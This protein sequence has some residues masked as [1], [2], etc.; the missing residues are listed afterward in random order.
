[1]TG[2]MATFAACALRSCNDAGALLMSKTFFVTLASEAGASPVSDGRFRICEN[3]AEEAAAN[4]FRSLTVDD[5]RLTRTR[6]LMTLSPDFMPA[7]NSASSPDWSCAGVPFAVVGLT[8]SETGTETVRVLV[9]PS[10]EGFAA[11]PAEFRK[12]SDRTHDA[13]PK[14][15]PASGRSL[16][17]MTKGMAAFP[18][19]G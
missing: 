7:A 4:S 19:G 17:S 15:E 16:R 8:V 11:L 9:P 14:S 10:G 1:M 3:D 2:L 13:V 5:R 12:V 6:S 18:P